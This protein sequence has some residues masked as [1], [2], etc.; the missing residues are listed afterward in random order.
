MQSAKRYFVFVFS[1]LPVRDALAAD[2]GSRLDVS[3]PAIL[4]LGLAA[5]LLAALIAKPVLLTLAG[6]LRDRAAERRLER[7]IAASGGRCLSGF[8]LPGVC[9]GLTQIDHA[10]LTAGGIVCIMHRNYRGT[11]FGESDDAQWTAVDGPERRQFMNPVILNRARAAALGKAMPG[12]PVRSLVVFDDAAEFASGRPG[13][14]IAVSELRN[15]LEGVEFEACGIAD[16]DA[17][18]LTL[19]SVALTDESSRQDLKAQVSF[20]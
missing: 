8:V 6:V 5:G 17:V 7:A 19:R 12:V 10:L 18:W 11:I 15:W 2:A 3:L 13:E 20:G 9:S 1:G 4:A 16:W 14:V